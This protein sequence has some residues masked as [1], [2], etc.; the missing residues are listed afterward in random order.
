MSQL[1]LFERISDLWMGDLRLGSSL[2]TKT[3]KYLK[4]AKLLVFEQ[5]WMYK[6]RMDVWK[7]NETI[8]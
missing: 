7:K 2:T 5:L 4:T 8:G 3:I 6:I 1:V